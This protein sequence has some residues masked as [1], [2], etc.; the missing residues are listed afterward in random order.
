MS[1]LKPQ[2]PNNIVV[3]NYRPGDEAKL[4]DFLNLCYGEWGTLQK[5]RNLYSNHPTFSDNDVFTIEK[6]NEIIGHESLHFRDLEM[7]RELVLSTVS[8][9]DAA[10]HPLYR[11]KGLHNRL[12][13]I[14]LEAAKSRGAALAYSWYLRGTGLHAHSKTIGFIEVKQPAAYM[15]VIRPEKV[16]KA[17]LSDFVQKNPK[18]KLVVQDFGDNLCLQFGKDKFS[19]QELLGIPS[20]KPAETGKRVEIVFDESSISVLAQ[21]R[22]LGKRQRLQHLILMLLLRKAKVRFRS[23][24]SLLNLARNG[25][26]TIGS[27]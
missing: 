20:K 13:E 21:F 5:W 14:M 3:R 4:V 25:V 27:I 10:T 24:G 8:L 18:L 17:G 23:L 19:I 6:G 15:K 9:S 7:Q 2:F 11:G 22:T 1:D 26:A 12:I 16:F